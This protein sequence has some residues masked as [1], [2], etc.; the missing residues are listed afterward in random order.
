MLESKC[1]LVSSRGILFSCD[2]HPQ[3]PVSDTRLLNEDD[4]RNIK[5]HD[6]VYV[7]TTCLP[8][9]V[10]NILPT[11][12]VPFVLVTGDSDRGAPCD[13]FNDVLDMNWADFVA[14]ELIVHWFCQ[15]IDLMM[16]THPKITPIPIGLD[17]H[18]LSHNDRHV[19]GCR[20]TPAEQEKDL[21][22]TRKVHPPLMSENRNVKMCMTNAVIHNKSRLTFA[23]ALENK[24]EMF[25]YIR[26]NRQYCW[27]KHQHYT[28][29]LSPIGNGLDCHR[30]WEALV[31]NT[32]PIINSPTLSRLCANLPVIVVDDW[33][34]VTR[35]FIM[36]Q[37]Q[38]IRE[39]KYTNDKLTLRYWMTLI[40]GVC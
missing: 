2:V 40:K 24:A 33:S 26:G 21:L 34:K 38:V 17:Y 20:K 5:P 25:D 15:N 19:W 37:L 22:N 13:I 1:A 12:R 18:T 4:Y 23:K 39:Q 36:D 8:S 16:E 9:F 3:N 32:V 10:K 7:I 35:E 14:N 11:V 30:T 29:V 6:T 28:C 31:L 27:D